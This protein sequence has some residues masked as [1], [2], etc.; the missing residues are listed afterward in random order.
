[1]DYDPGANATRLYDSPPFGAEKPL[2]SCP[3]RLERFAHR[4][5]DLDQKRRRGRRF[6][7]RLG[8]EPAIV[9]QRGLGL[10]PVAELGLGHGDQRLDF[11]V[12]AGV[13]FRGLIPP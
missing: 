13:A 8:P 3:R 7:V 12:L 1:M 10:S 2:T 5:L 11:G 4:L 6:R 9:G